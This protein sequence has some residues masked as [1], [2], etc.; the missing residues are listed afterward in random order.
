M[1]HYLG[2]AGRHANSLEQHVE[3]MRL[4]TSSPPLLQPEFDSNRVT[5]AQLRHVA[6][7]YGGPKR[8]A[9]QILLASAED[10][11]AAAA[12]AAADENDDA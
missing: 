4:L 8:A 7:T 5:I 10:Y 12:A 11:N 9:V 3:A 6:Q 1:H 2:H